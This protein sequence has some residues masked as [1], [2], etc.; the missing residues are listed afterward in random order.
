MKVSR[1]VVIERPIDEVW[2][3]YDDL[4]NMVEWQDELQSYELVEGEPDEVGSTRNQTIKQMGVTQHLK[5]TLLERDPPHRTKSLYEGAQ[6]PFT[7]EDE[8]IDL[9][10]GTTE[11]T[12]TIDVRLNMLQ[13]ALEL[14]L[15]PLASDLTKRNGKNFK[16]FC[17]RR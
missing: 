15:K 2:A 5:V 10:D 12:A 8:F 3:L 4:D 11:W 17:E 6:A 1:T 14:V 16:E 9:G 13:K 7:A